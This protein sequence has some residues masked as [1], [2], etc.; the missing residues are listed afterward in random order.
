[1]ARNILKAA[2]LALALGAALVFQTTAAFASHPLVTNDAGTEGKGHYLLE[3]NTEYTHDKE[4]G[5]KE[6]GAELEVAFTAGLRDNLDLA[7]GVPYAWSRVKEGGAVT[8]E[9]DGVSDVSVELKWKFFEHEGLALALK[10]EVT[11][12][13]G[14]EDRG[15]GNGRASYSMAFIL[16]REFERWALHANLSYARNEFKLDADDDA[17]RHDIWHA[18]VAAEFSATE[19]LK[20]VGNVG[21]ETNPERESSTCPAFA[22]AGLVYSVTDNVSVDA[23]VKA[24]LTSTETDLAVLAG[25]AISF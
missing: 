23:G 11:L 13:T 24:G 8:S 7:L 21:V 18:S 25:V 16:S 20:V 2:A 22:L 12:P 14:D 5:A 6:T 15:L 1:M 17:N 9:E 3:I 10:P 19:R 4:D